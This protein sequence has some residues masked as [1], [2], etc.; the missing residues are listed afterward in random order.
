MSE[1]F[2]IDE[3]PAVSQGSATQK[4][5]TLW[6][7]LVTTSKSLWKQTLIIARKSETVVQLPL[8]LAI[9]LAV[10]FPHL[11]AL[12]LVLGIVLGY[13]FTVVGK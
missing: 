7:Q 3:R 11:A 6:D 4:K 10:G 9:L 1:P 13:S 12:V 5:P 2:N 8:V